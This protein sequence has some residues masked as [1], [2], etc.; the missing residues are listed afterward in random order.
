MMFFKLP[1]MVRKKETLKLQVGFDSEKFGCLLD[2]AL[3]KCMSV[4]GKTFEKIHGEYDPHVVAEA[5]CWKCG[6]RWIAT[7]PE[8]TLLKQLQC[9]HCEEQGFAFLTNQDLDAIYREE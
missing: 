9:P 8:N 4:G 1:K 2:E 7:F 3:S 5:M 6:H